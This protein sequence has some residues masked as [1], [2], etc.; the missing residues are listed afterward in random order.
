[1]SDRHLGPAEVGSPPM[2]PIF[3]QKNAMILEDEDPRVGEAESGGETGNR[4][5]DESAVRVK[6]AELK[7][8]DV[9]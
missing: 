4:D 9:P 8:A 1:M 5:H 2:T 3:H 6:T 7:L